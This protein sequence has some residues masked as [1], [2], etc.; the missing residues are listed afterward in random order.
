M[1]DQKGGKRVVAV[2]NEVVKTKAGTA[3]LNDMAELHIKVGE[4]LKVTLDGET[5]TVKVPAGRTVDLYWD[6]LK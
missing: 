2:L 1:W 4:I 6:Q 3:D 5:R